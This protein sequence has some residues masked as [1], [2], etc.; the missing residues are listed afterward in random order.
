MLEIEIWERIPCHFLDLQ[1]KVIDFFDKSK[2]PQ[3]LKVTPIK[4]GLDLSFDTNFDLI[5]KE[6]FEN[7]NQFP[8]CKSY[9]RTTV[10]E[11]RLFF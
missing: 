6:V 3:K 5:S 2:I 7:S 8:F 10:N 11:T 1:Q 9:P 4:L